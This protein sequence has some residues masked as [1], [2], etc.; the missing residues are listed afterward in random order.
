MPIIVGSPRSGT[1]LLRFMLDAHPELAIPPETGF[2]AGCSQIT[3]SGARLRQ[4][5]FDLVTRFPPDAPAW[6]DFEIS[7]EVFWASLARIDPFTISEGLR[8]FYQ[9]YASRFGKPRWGDKTPLYCHRLETVERFLPEARF[10]HII[11]DGRD[12][13]LSLRPMRFSPGDDIELLAKYWSRLV[14]TAREQGVRCRHYVEIRYEELVE[15]TRPVLE[16]LCTYLGLEFDEQMLHYYERTPD[17]LREHK[18]RFG[19]DGTLQLTQEQRYL[20]QQRTTVAPDRSRVRA[21]RHEM[22]REER[23]MFDVVA[24][25]VLRELG[26]EV[27]R[28]DGE[29]QDGN[30][31]GAKSNSEDSEER[32]V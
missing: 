15:N 32:L 5:F 12:V 30:R 2:V 11:R 27:A 24:G 26:Y 23:M 4:E 22:S 6:E 8:A 31:L 20:Q 28:H 7:R 19:S 3:S 9:L 13:A 1:T 18:G 17:R 25:D 14:L 10:I 29:A 21:W 16:R